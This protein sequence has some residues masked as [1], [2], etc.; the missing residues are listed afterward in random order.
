MPEHVPILVPPI[1]TTE[2]DAGVHRTLVLG[3][4]PREMR[5]VPRS[6]RR[7]AHLNICHVCLGECFTLIDYKGETVNFICGDC[8]ED[9]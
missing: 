6:K 2:L 3:C 1:S 4:S 9:A 7:K 5:K 8:S